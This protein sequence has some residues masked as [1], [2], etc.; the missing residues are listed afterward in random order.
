MLLLVVVYRSC[1]WLFLFVVARNLLIVYGICVVV[2]FVVVDIVVMHTLFRTG[3]SSSHWADQSCAYLPAD[4]GAHSRGEDR[5]AG[6]D[7]AASGSDS[8]PAGQAGGQSPEDR[9]QRDAQHD[10][11]RC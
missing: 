5:G 8:H 4:H 10:P 6:R 2:L 11:S 9:Q 3:P 1:R 7:E